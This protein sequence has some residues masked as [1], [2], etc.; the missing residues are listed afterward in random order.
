ML[1]K[2]YYQS[3]KLFH[4]Y[5][6]FLLQKSLYVQFYRGAI[7]FPPVGSSSMF[8]LHGW[9][10]LKIPATDKTSYSVQVESKSDV[11]F[12]PELL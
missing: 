2:E 3:P 10:N 9:G 8:L 12:I 4:L 1:T 11:H 5:N 6:E 7:L